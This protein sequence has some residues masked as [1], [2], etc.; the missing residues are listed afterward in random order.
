MT[1]MNRIWIVELWNDARDR[2]EPTIGAAI[3]KE[4]C[5]AVRRDWLR[6]NPTDRFRVWRY[7][8]KSTKP[9]GRR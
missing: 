6:R 8:A 3:T 4:E 9:K 5:Y 1:E 2:F 7:E